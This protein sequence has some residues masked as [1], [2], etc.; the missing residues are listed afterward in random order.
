MDPARRGRAIGMATISEGARPTAPSVRAGNV[1]A[2]RPVAPGEPPAFQIRESKLRPIPSRPAAVGRRALLDRLSRS[3]APVTVVLAPAG[4]GKTTLLAEWVDELSNPVAWLTTDETDNDPV[5]LCTYLAAALDR[6]ELVPPGVFSA[7]AS[8]LP[9]AALSNQLVAILEAMT[10]PVTVVVDH[11]DSVTNPE[12]MA[13]VAEVA[14]RLP[15][16]VRLVLASRVEPRLPMARLRVEGRLLEIGMDDLA[17]DLDE[18]AGLLVGAGIDIDGLDVQALV[19]R[20]EGWP[21]GLFLAGLA[22]QVAPSRGDSARSIRG[23]SRYLGDYLRAEVLDQVSAEE[24]AFLVRTSILDSLS[25][26]LCDATLDAEGSSDRLEAMERRRLL[27][28]PLDGR[29]E[30]YRYQRLFGELLRSELHRREPALVPE[31]HARAAAWYQANGQPEEALRHAQVAKDGDLVSDLLHG[32]MQS[33]W[34]SGRAGTVMR[35]MEW[36]AEEDLLDRYPALTVHGA[37]M[38]ALLGYPAQAEVWAAAAER[39]QVDIGSPD[40]STMESLL[41]YLGAF[42]CRHGAASMRADSITAFDGLS[43]TSPYRASMLFTEGLSHV[44]EGDPDRAEPVLVRACDAAAAIGTVPVEAMVLAVL[45]QLAADRNDWP[46]A[47]AL[48]DRALRLLD[49]GAFDEYWTSALVFAWGARLASRAGRLS[50]ARDLLARAARL[51]PQL[52]YALP[53]VSTMALIE[54]ARVYIALALSLIHI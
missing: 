25:G 8:R 33:V 45:S 38:Y 41:A 22:M 2:A 6:V 42:Q 50:D 10:G 26:P 52:T 35:W 12:C 29:H 3:E 14:S 28:V 9:P 31:L 34:A 53:V 43:P 5:A 4:Y 23:D 49:D 24:S 47:D 20:T 36:L 18:A 27:I 54:M 1:D 51:R 32:L 46:D 19:D 48:G 13:L 30:W 17:L 16:H 7:L 15:D 44:I 40:G 11:L 37:L 21:A 39:T